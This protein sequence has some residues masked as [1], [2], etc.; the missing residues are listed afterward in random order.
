[1]LLQVRIDKTIFANLVL[2]NEMLRTK[3]KN[4]DA[5]DVTDSALK[6]KNP[7]HPCWVLAHPANPGY[8]LWL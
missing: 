6:R 8:K 7:L 4:K 3:Y 1:M 5:Q 2:V